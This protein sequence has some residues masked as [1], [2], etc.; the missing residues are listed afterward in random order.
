MDFTVKTRDSTGGLTTQRNSFAWE[1]RGRLR[2]KASID[3]SRVV[4]DGKRKF[5]I[6]E[7]PGSEYDGPEINY[8]VE[9]MVDAPAECLEGILASFPF[10]Y[11]ARILVNFLC[12]VND[13]TPLKVAETA[14]QE[15]FLGLRV[16]VLPAQPF[17]GQACDLV[18]VTWSE[19]GRI[20]GG[21][22]TEQETLWFSRKDGR[23]MRDQWRSSEGKEYHETNDV[24]YIQQDLNPSFPTNYFTYTPPKG[25]VLRKPQ[26]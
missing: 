20:F 6:E 5:S 16:V 11:P 15:G 8:E 14:Q 19:K 17:Q 3:S 9:P 2:N 18:R 22:H 4:M 7:H 26:L 24:Q 21:I 12:G 25:A 1:R 13:L 23:V 10:S